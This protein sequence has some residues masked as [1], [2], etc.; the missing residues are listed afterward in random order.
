M[1]TSKTDQGVREDNRPTDQASALR[2]PV[3]GERIASTDPLVLPSWAMVSDKRRGHI[4]RVVALI[5]RWA[6]DLRLAPDRARAWHDAALWHDALRDAP[7]SSLREISGDHRSE[8]NLLHGPAAAARLVADNERR[9]D[10]IEAVRWHT[11]GN[12]GWADAGRALYMADFLE[13]GRAFARADRA[14]LAHQVPL[15]FDGTFR[16][17]VRTRLEWALREGKGLLEETVALW[18]AVR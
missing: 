7:E 1:T 12:A 15:D 18:N 5:D 14:Y 16:Q 8:A 9:P 4:M 11:V 6:V 10:V 2:A 13:P 3:P 17:V